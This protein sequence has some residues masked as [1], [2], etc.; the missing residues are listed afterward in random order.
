MTLVRDKEM[1]IACDQ[2]LKARECFM[3]SFAV[4]PLEQYRRAS[5]RLFA[6]FASDWPNEDY[7]SL[8]KAFRTFRQML[9]EIHDSSGGY[10]AWWPEGNFVV[11]S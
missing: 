11:M 6:A 1:E 8:S 5:E 10:P 2:W 7:P 9:V 4:K 3:K